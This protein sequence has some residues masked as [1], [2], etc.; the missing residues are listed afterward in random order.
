[1]KGGL[2]PSSLFYTH[3]LQ[4]P[5]LPFLY[6]IFDALTKEVRLMLVLSL[7]KLIFIWIRLGVF[8]PAVKPELV[9]KV[10][11]NPQY[12]PERLWVAVWS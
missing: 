7:D 8:T 2:N 11:S 5:S 10:K 12:F 4:V 3:S 6:L 1:M 9:L